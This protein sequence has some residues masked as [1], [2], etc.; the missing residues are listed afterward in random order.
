MCNF[1]NATVYADYLLCPQKLSPL[2]T[3]GVI[4]HEKTVIT[5]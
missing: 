2:L 1:F 5:V 4:A 3:L